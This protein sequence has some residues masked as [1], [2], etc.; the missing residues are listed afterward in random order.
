MRRDHGERQT[1]AP[2]ETGA[3]AATLDHPLHGLQQTIGNQAVQR[4]LGA[5]QSGSRL[6]QRDFKS[7][8]DGKTSTPVA[9]NAPAPPGTVPIQTIPEKG[10]TATWVNAPYGIYSPGEIPREHHGQI[11]ESGKAFQWRNDGRITEGGL[12]REA[13][14]LA[15]RGELTVGDML[16]LSR[17]GGTNMNIRIA[18]A[19]V[20]NDFR[21]VGYD[22]SRGDA[23]EAVYAGFVESEKG[24]TRGVGRAL[25]ADR[26][27]RALLNRASGM[28]L[29]VYTSDRTAKFHAE[30][31]AAAGRSGKPIQGQHYRLTT[32][33][34]V[35]LAVAW[36][37]KLSPSQVTNLNALLTGGGNVSAAAAESALLRG[38]VQDRPPPKGSGGGGPGA[39]GGPPAP[40]TSSRAQAKGALLSWG[41]QALLAKQISNMQSAEKGKALARFAELSPEIG[42]LLDEN[43]AVTVTVEVEV[44][45]SVNIAGVITQ[46]DPSMIVYYRNMYIDRAIKI[47]PPKPAGEVEQSGYYPVGEVADKY[48]NPRRWDDPHEYTLD[49]QIRVQMG[50][51]DPTGKDRPKHST[52]HVMKRSQTFTPQI[53]EALETVKNNPQ[54]AAP[55]PKPEPKIDDATAKKLAAAPTRVGMLT[56]NVIQYKLAAQIRDSMK[57]SPIFRFTTEGMAGGAGGS[58][59]R[60]IYWSEYDKPRAEALA[61]VVRAAGVPA[62]RVESGGNPDATPG[63]VQINFGSDAEK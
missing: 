26:I 46:S 8:F 49:Q 45:K 7:D 22:M 21:F 6:L 53:V 63:Y 40:I 10:K 56:G 24:T 15:N 27:T 4:L 18:M 28:N 5:R 14:R 33:E 59:T 44:P 39:G 43:Y 37:P 12:D 61:E 42:R 13:A 2:A 47:R 55:P 23:G 31:Y 38:A 9:A 54:P 3:S 16:R 17:R 19:K 32:A 60:V 25:F 48:S 57:S 11:M 52:H 34:M 29:E 41:A 1:P 50:D 35:K 58:R 20:G 30:I 51:P 62:T 36:N